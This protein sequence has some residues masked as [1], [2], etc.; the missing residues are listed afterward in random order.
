MQTV[1]GTD[2]ANEPTWVFYGVSVFIRI[3]GHQS[4]TGF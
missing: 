4:D 3:P 2:A 1:G